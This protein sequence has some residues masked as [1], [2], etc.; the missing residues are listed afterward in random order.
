MNPSIEAFHKTGLT[1]FRPFLLLG[2]SIGTVT[3][4]S[5]SRSSSTAWCTLAKGS[6]TK[7][8]KRWLPRQTPTTMGKLTTTSLAKWFWVK[9]RDCSPSFPLFRN[10]PS[11]Q[12]SL[13][14]RG[15]HCA[16]CDCLNGYFEVLKMWAKPSGTNCELQCKYDMLGLAW[17]VCWVQ[18]RLQEN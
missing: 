13:P 15:G 12:W 6:P 7:K 18:L 16:Q 17:V 3:V 14:K 2:C 9:L 5:A 4:T 1:V 11:H 10:S 8:W